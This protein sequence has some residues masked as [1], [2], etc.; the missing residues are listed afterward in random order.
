MGKFLFLK[1]DSGEGKTTLLFECLKPWHRM[2]GGFYSQRLLNE[3]GLTMGFRMVPAAEEWIPAAAYKKGM[4]N[5]FIQRNENGFQKNLQFFKTDGIEILRSSAHNKLLLL[6]EI[7]GIE[8]FVP[9]FMKE[10]LCCID[11]QVPCI[12][13]LKSQKNL[14]AMRTRVPTEPD[15]DKLLRDLEEKLVKRSDGRI[16]TFDREKKE[17]IRAEIMEFLRECT[18]KEGKETHGRKGLDI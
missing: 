13:V 9:D 12:G 15:P 6:D 10:V 2:V 7:G 5:V 4:T 14:E 18:E 17:H 11:S 16:L 8:L 3:D 1:G